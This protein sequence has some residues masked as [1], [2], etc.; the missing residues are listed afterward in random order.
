[1]MD[2]DQIIASLEALLLEARRPDEKPTTLFIPSGGPLQAALDGDAP[3]IELDPNGRYPGV[4]IGR[5]VELRCHG[6][7]LHGESVPA[8]YI[9]PGPKSVDIAV[10]EPD[11]SSTFQNVYQIGDNGKTQATIDRV[12]HGILFFRPIIRGH[13]GVLAKN[14][15]ENN[16]AGVIIEQPEFRDIYNPNRVESHG[17]VT[18][19]TP[20]GLKVLGGTVSGASTPLFT[21]GDAI[22]IPEIDISDIRYEGVTITRPAEWQL[23]L[24]GAFKNLVEFKNITHGVVTKC[25]IFNNW[26]PIQ[27]GF[28][29]MLTPKVDGRVV[30]VEFSDNDIYNVGSGF[31]ILGK[32]PTGEDTTRT[33]NIRILNNRITIDNKVYGP[34]SFGW[35]F[36]LS[37]GPG[38]IRIEGNTI[39]HNGTSFIYVDGP[40]RIASLI[41]RGN[42]TNLGDYGIR[43][44]FGNNGANWQQTFDELIVEGNTFS[45]ASSVFKRNFPNNTWV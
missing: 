6:A 21:G 43:T 9:L 30:D 29:C 19:N 16:G 31:N 4:R 23:T 13:N 1:M 38:R 14:G 24:D 28:A 40:E 10:M 27:K 5:P 45:G 36:L 34:S 35:P 42:I 39:S 11:G 32:N 12:P 18:I 26:G 20:G 17:I 25:Q 2:R 44:P 8:I 3:T 37:A 41:V 33:D 7:R 15:L 22:D